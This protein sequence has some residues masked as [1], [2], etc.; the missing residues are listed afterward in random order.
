LPVFFMEVDHANSSCRTWHTR[1]GA[2]ARF[3][4]VKVPAFV[5]PRGAIFVRLIVHFIVRIF[6]AIKWISCERHSCV[7]FIYEN[8]GVLVKI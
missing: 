2:S 6:W 3:H 1:G 4:F 5:V 7:G 8:S